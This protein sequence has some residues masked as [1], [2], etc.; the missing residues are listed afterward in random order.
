P[1][2]RQSSPGGGRFAPAPN[3]AHALNPYQAT[4]RLPLNNPGALRPNFPLNH[5]PREQAGPGTGLPANG[6]GVY[7]A[8]APSPA[9]SPGV[10]M[11]GTGAGGTAAGQQPVAPAPL[12]Q[13]VVL[14]PLPAAGSFPHTRPGFPVVERKDRF[15]PLV[16]DR[17]FMTLHGVRHAFVPATLLGV[18][19]ID[20]SYWYPDGYVSME[21]PACTGTTADG[22]QLEWRMVDFEDGEGEPQPQ[23][24]QYCP[25][26]GP[27]PQQVATLPPAP[28]IAEGGECQTTIYSEPNFAGNSAPTG[29]SQPILSTT[30]WRNE[31]AS[32]VVAAG[33]WDFFTEENFGGE[34]LRLT[35]GTY[36]RLAPEW[37]RHIGSF[38]CVKP[39]PPP[40]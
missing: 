22:C 34:S 6:P 36:P 35:A 4:P 24:V 12:R 5:Q 9:P 7:A 33:T 10:N 15:F 18:V 20:G 26:A 39:A 21:G 19:L 16:R 23:C 32:I 29:D 11:P 8:P 40:A 37:T 28:A 30:G 38:M 14:R 27:P 17:K 25:Q 2:F 3:A 31:I 13:P 1:T